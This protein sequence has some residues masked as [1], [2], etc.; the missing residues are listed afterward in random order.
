MEYFE[1][2][3]LIT[4]SFKEPE[5]TVIENYFKL[6]VIIIASYNRLKTAA[7]VE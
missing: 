6:S 5:G 3:V 2:S 4:L 7:S 1:L